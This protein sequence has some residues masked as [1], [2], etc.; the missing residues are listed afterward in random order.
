MDTTP[1]PALDAPPVST[2]SADE[3]A[4]ILDAVRDFAAAEFA[5]HTLEWDAEKHFPATS[6]VARASWVS[7][8][9]TSTTTWAAPG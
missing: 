6:C 4:A 9:S 2:L 1:A 8:A 7:A 5:P 3:R